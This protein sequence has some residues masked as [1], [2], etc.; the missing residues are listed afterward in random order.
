MAGINK[1]ILVGNIGQDPGNRANGKRWSPYQCFASDVTI[2]KDKDSG[3]Q[4]EKTEWHRVV[5]F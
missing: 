3:E 5:F 1:V 4:K 2:L